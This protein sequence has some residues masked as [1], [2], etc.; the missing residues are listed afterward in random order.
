MTKTAT[1][2]AA[3]TN[4]T[5][6]ESSSTS[7]TTANASSHS[8]TTNGPGSVPERAPPASGPTDGLQLL[9]LNQDQP[10]G[11]NLLLFLPVCPSQTDRFPAAACPALPLSAMEV[12]P[13]M[14][15]PFKIPLL[16]P[17]DFVTKVE[18]DQVGDAPLDLSMKCSAASPALS[19]TPLQSVKSEPAALEPH[20]DSGE[21]QASLVSVEVSS[22]QTETY[23]EESV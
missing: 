21:S 19:N 3:S 9:S 23:T 5:T 8:I 15:T 2:L 10:S 11:V 1:P 7:T 17:F 12:Q 6:S 16:A 13:G 14:A 18:H 22:A 20:G 4:T